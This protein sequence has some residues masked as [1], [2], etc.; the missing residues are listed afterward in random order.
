METAKAVEAAGAAAVTVHGRTREQYYEGSANWD[1]IA[2]VKKS[3]SIPVIGN[4]DVTS[5]QAAVDMMDRTGC[6]GVMIA[7]GALG[8]PWIFREAAAIWEWGEAPPPPTEEERIAMLME[9]F[10][11]LVANKGENEIV[12]ILGA[13]NTITDAEE[14]KRAILS[15]QG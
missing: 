15:R 8:Y 5:G 13:C 1:V 12:V 10:R 4:G 3:V 2:R 7:R 14:M 6:D 9:H 11:L